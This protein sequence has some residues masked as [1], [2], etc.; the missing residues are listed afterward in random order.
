MFLSQLL[1]ATTA[2]NHPGCCPVVL[3]CEIHNGQK[4]RMGRGEV[5][6]ILTGV[7]TEVITVIEHLPDHISIK[8]W[9]Q[10]NS[11]IFS[12]LRTHDSLKKEY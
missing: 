9:H 7:N 1:T 4:E 3:C 2:F 10:P 11:A 12:F 6:L 5:F 8:K